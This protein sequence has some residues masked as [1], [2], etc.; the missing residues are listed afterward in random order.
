[1][2]LAPT[3]GLGEDSFGTVASSPGSEKGVVSRRA[4]PAAGLSTSPGAS[5]LLNLRIAG[6]CHKLTVRAAFFFFPPF[7]PLL[8]IWVL[9]KKVY[10]LLGAWKNRIRGG[11]FHAGSAD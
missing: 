10:I 1:M 2:Q 4:E 11:C 9:F 8:K 3:P 6:V 5:L 7:F